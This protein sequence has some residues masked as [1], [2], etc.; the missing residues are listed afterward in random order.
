MP[1]TSRSLVHVVGMLL[2]SAHVLSCKCLA[3]DS[4]PEAVRAS[5]YSREDVLAPDHVWRVLQ[6]PNTKGLLHGLPQRLF[7][8]LAPSIRKTPTWTGVENGGILKL[9]IE[10]DG[11]TSSEIFVGLFSDPR[12]YVAEPVQVRQ[13]D[14]PGEYTLQNLPPGRF[15]V[16]AMAG[17]RREENGA[18]L[19]PAAIG[20]HA[21]WPEPV[22]IK[23][24]DT[25][26]AH[27]KLFADLIWS[28]AMPWDDESGHTGRWERMNP[29][30]L[31]TV[32][33]LDADNDPIPYC[34]VVFVE[35]DEEVTRGF[36]NVATDQ[37]G[38]AYCDRINGTFSLIVQP[39]E[40]VPEL[41]ASRYHA[42]KMGKLHSTETRPLIEVKFDSFPEGAGRI[43]GRVRDQN[44]RPVREFHLQI[45]TQVG[46]R[47]DWSEAH[48]YGILIPVVD[49]E[50]RFEVEHLAPGAYSIS[51]FPFD[52]DSHV[53]KWDAATFSVPDMPQEAVKVDVELEARELRYGRAVYEDGTPVY[54]G[55]WSAVFA[56]DPVTGVRDARSGRIQRDGTFRVALS[57]SELEKLDENLD[58]TI[59][60]R[61]R[62]HAP[63]PV[64]ARFDQLSADADRPFEVVFPNPEEQ[65]AREATGDRRAANGSN[66]VLTGTP[67]AA[68]LKLL[69]TT[70]MVHRLSDY[71]GQPVVLNAFATWCGPCH[72]QTPELVKLHER[73]QESGLIVL[74]ISR[75]EEPEPVEEFVQKDLIPFPV[76]VDPEE[77]LKELVDQDGRAVFPKNED[78][79]IS[80]PT[81][82]VLDRD[83]RAVYSMVGFN[84]EKLP[85]LVSAVERVTR[86]VA[87]NSPTME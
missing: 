13:F 30:T 64:T 86:P 14:G 9:K 27:V 8:A 38:F 82:V 24:G 56:T 73:L 45:T 85:E 52:L 71:R 74:M 19:N 36:Q 80:L 28:N 48:S 55:A 68:D 5:P 77:S 65:K 31:A 42:W 35:R 43:V 49:P 72:S 41:R 83:H 21:T 20:I 62:E 63:A 4:P 32:R 15:W 3:D 25:A 78:G 81:T 57:S 29:V 87:R 79:G 76:L 33:V 6:Q 53:L 10:V 51:A 39:H 40:I 54:P 75:G 22:E 84:K 58:G 50:G 37:L 61:C 2:C 44:D 18:K 1:M 69:D 23:R 59:T 66:G 67:L 16:G 47:R 11:N 7:R 46:E 17:L 26:E 70:G 34:R 12:W 60:V